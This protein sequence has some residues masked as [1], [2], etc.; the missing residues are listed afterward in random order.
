MEEMQR[1]IQEFVQYIQQEVIRYAS[2]RRRRSVERRDRPGQTADGS[3][4]VA[5]GPGKSKGVRT[6]PTPSREAAEQG[7]Q[8]TAQAVGEHAD[9]TQPREGRKRDYG[10]AQVSNCAANYY[11]NVLRRII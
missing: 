4:D 6:R 7:R 5:G 8:P 11:V 1:Q 2:E 10:L 3:A 9:R